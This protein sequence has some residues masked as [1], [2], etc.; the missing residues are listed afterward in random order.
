MRW[1]AGERFEKSQPKDYRYWFGVLCSMPLLV[2][3]GASLKP[4]FDLSGVALWIAVTAFGLCAFAVAHLWARFLPAIA[5]LILS[6]PAWVG[7][8]FWVAA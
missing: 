1:S 8:Y 7:F 4:V 6:I 3:G 5:S 2:M